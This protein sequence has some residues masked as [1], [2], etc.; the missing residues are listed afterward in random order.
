MES[1]GWRGGNA[2]A[3]ILVND[4][5]VLIMWDRRDRVSCRSRQGIYMESLRSASYSK[6]DGEGALG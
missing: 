6:R 1:D 4:P 5:C 2:P 3:L